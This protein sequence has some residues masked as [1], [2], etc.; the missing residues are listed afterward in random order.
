MRIPKRRK[1]KVIEETERCP[2]ADPLRK[3]RI[4]EGKEV[5]ER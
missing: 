2:V 4:A 3:R 1:G 5:K